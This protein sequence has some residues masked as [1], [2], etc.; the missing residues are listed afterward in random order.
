MS[1][2]SNNTIKFIYEKNYSK[3]FNGSNDSRICGSMY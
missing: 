2:E 3:V 1:G